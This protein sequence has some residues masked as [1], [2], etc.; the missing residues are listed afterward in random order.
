MQTFLSPLLGKPDTAW[1]SRR[2]QGA[3]PRAPGNFSSNSA[4]FLGSATAMSLAALGASYIGCRCLSRPWRNTCPA[5]PKAAKAA[6]TRGLRHVAVRSL[7][8]KFFEK[9]DTDIM[10]DTL[11]QPSAVDNHRVAVC[12]FPK[13]EITKD[14]I[15]RLE[16][17]SKSLQWISL[18]DA[19]DLVLEMEE[20][21]A[22]CDVA[23]ICPPRSEEGVTAL[24]ATLAGLRSVLSGLPN[25]L[26]KV[27]LLSQVSA[28]RSRLGSFIPFFRQ[29]RGASWDDIEHELMSAARTCCPLQAV[30]IRIGTHCSQV[31]SAVRCLPLD[32]VIDGSTSSA[33]A[34]QAIFHALEFGVDTSFAVVEEPF[35]LEVPSRSQSWSEL[36]LPFVGPELWRA[37]VDDAHR[38]AMFVQSWAEEFFR[39]GKGALRFG[40][41]TP[42]DMRKTAT[43]VILKYRPPT[44]KARFEDLQEGGIEFIAEIPSVGHARL[45]AKR[46]AYGWKVSCKRNSE[47]AL[48]HK[49]AQDWAQGEGFHRQFSPSS[50]EVSDE[51]LTER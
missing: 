26:R 12:G 48:M 46:C 42:V 32:Q 18:A 16:K 50:P 25:G 38:A 15:S 8:K 6:H 43:G 27:V 41:K 1:G 29:Y 49:F 23:I 40:V 22:G 36:L 9:E 5:F 39:E 34:A 47:K 11:K 2:Q 30:I 51:I 20:K 10:H 7:F 37:E 13:D 24:S 35:G 31:P 44:A 21:L 14:L 17:T 4:D 28:Q 19:P 45:R 33:V 3:T